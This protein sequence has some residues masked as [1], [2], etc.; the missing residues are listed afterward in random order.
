MLGHTHIIMEILQAVL[1]VFG[2]G[3]NGNAAPLKI[4]NIS[5]LANKSTLYLTD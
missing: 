4:L 1:S 3:V 5:F 2:T